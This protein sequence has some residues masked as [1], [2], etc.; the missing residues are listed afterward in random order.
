MEYLPDHVILHAGSALRQSLRIE[1]QPGSRGIFLDSFAAGRVTQN[2]LWRFREFDSRTEITLAGK[3]LY[4]SR[5]K[6]TPAYPP[7]TSDSQLAISHSLP[8]VPL[9]H[10]PCTS[11]SPL[12]EKN[13]P[14]FRGSKLQLRHYSSGAAGALAP[15]EPDLPWFAIHPSP[16]A[17]HSP[18]PY[19]ASLL[20][21]ADQLPDW[22][23]VVTQPPRRTRRRPGSNRRRQRT[24]GIRLLR[25][26][27]GKLRDSAARSHQPPLDR[28]PPRSFQPPAARPPQILKGT[29]ALDEL[30]KSGGQ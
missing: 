14:P 16:N 30:Q 24:L 28:G 25:P 15:E 2:E 29:P 21:V 8:A 20:I 1:M 6:L 4:A 22:R 27:H 13:L 18:P 19:S 12:P 26:L 3:L 7:A 9:C 23:P 11:H 10:P 17:L 5:A